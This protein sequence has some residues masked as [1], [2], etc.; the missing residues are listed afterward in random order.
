MPD[1]SLF[2]NAA[3]LYSR[4]ALPLARV[5]SFGV[6]V[7]MPV[8]LVVMFENWSVTSSFAA[9]R[10]LNSVTAFTAFSPVPGTT[11]VT[12]PSAVA[13]Q[14]KP[15]GTPVTVKSECAVLVSKVPS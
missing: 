15:V 13:V 6:M 12:V 9:L 2:V 8:A 14:V 3:P 10:I 11:F 5:T 4:V 7:S 1:T